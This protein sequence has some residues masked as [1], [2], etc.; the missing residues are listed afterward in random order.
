M[1][2][3]LDLIHQV[4]EVFICVNYQPPQLL[5][6]GDTTNQGNDKDNYAYDPVEGKSKA[7]AENSQ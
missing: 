5:N 4:V 6:T 2:T 3:L 7:E 1:L